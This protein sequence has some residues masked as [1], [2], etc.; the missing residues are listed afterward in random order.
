MKIFIL[1]VDGEFCSAHSNKKSAERALELL[2]WDDVVKAEI[3]GV[4]LY[5]LT[6]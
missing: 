6:F 4:P 3:K 1:I 5:T 2:S